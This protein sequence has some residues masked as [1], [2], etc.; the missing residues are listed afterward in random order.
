LSNTKYD[1][2]PILEAK[3]E[4]IVPKK[5]SKIPAKYHALTYLLELEMNNQKPPTNADGE[6]KKDLIIIEGRQRCNDSG[7]N[8]YNTVRDHHHHISKNIIKKT[9]F[10]TNWKEIVLGLTE[11]KS[12]LEKFIENN[13][14]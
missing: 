11:N 9:I 14:L 8:F 1:S 5:S 2:A 10:K 12:E 7:Q 6:F 13:S 4:I 3:K